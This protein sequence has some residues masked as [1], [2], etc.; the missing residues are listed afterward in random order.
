MWPS[1]GLLAGQPNDRYESS[2]KWKVLLVTAALTATMVS[3]VKGVG[4][5]D[6]RGVRRN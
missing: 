1:L 2:V 5:D 4:C 6:L 3:S